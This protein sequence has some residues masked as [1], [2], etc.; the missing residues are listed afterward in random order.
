MKRLSLLLVIVVLLAL[1]AGSVSAAPPSPVKGGGEW[2]H[3]CLDGDKLNVSA[4]ADNV[5]RYE[6]IGVSLYG[7]SELCD[8]KAMMG[9]TTSGEN[10]AIYVQCGF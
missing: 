8:K 5:L 3:I 4:L 7:W 1:V 10:S 2:N 6:C 9:Y